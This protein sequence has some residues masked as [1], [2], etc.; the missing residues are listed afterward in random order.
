MKKSHLAL[1]V[2]LIVAS[3][4]IGCSSS[5]KAR[6]TEAP[7]VESSEPSP[8][9]LDLFIKGVVYDQQGEITRA[10]ASYRKALQFDSTSASIYLALAEDY[11]ALNLYDDVFEHLHSALRYEPLNAE[12]ISFLSDLYLRMNLP[13]SAAYYVE[14]I[15]D[16]HPG[17]N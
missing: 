4:F 11:L 6:L 9:A 2:I 17:D 1:F 7:V 16:A 8:Q 3:L 12:V 15:V 14:R 13:D 5:R 10:I